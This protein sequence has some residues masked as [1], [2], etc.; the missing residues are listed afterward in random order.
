MGKTSYITLILISLLWFLL[1]P[2]AIILHNV[3]SDWFGEGS[4][5]SI[6]LF[7]LSI[8]LILGVIIPIGFL[9]FN[10]LKSKKKK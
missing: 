5:L 9:L 7:T 1:I 2:L 3:F 10:S 8:I 4:F 6:G